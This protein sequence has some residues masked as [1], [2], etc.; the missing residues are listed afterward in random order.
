M[1]SQF[2]YS[3]MRCRMS[4]LN[5][6]Y[7]SS[8][9]AI[10]FAFRQTI[11]QSLWWLSFQNR[12][13]VLQFLII[14]AP[15]CS[16]RKHLNYLAH[17]KVE[18]LQIPFIS[19]RKRLARR[20]LTYFHHC[21]EFAIEL[22]YSDPRYL[23]FYLTKSWLNVARVRCT[24]VTHLFGTIFELNKTDAERRQTLGHP[25]SINLNMI[26]HVPQQSPLIF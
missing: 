20:W 21:N 12:M 25:R 22:V 4:V 19:P 16:C 13:I 1:L 15:L 6:K 23:T 11:S 24:K 10:E 9:G 7:I 3:R 18:K 2:S 5:Y 14:F 26:N 17:C 8:L